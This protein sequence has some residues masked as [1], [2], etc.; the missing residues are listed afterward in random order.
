MTTTKELRVLVLAGEPGA[1]L[2]PVR[3]RFPD[4]ATFTCQSYDALPAALREHQPTIVLAAKIGREPFPRQTLVDSSSVQWIQASSAGVD[5]LQPLR[6]GI[7]LTSARGVHDDVLA[8]YV[9]CSVLMFNLHF[10]EFFRQQRDQVWSPQALEPTA[11]QCLVVVGL[12]SIGQLAAEKARKLGM[13]V[14]GVRA[15]PH[16]ALSRPELAPPDEIHAIDRLQEVAARADF[17][18]VTL[19]L[20]P[21]TRCLVGA[22]ILGSMKKG[23][24]LINISRGGIVDEKALVRFLRDG[25]LGGAV[26]DVFRE[27]PLPA[28]SELWNVDNLVITPHTGDIR[29]ARKKVVELFLEN[30]SRWKEGNPLLNIVDPERGY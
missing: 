18:A 8:D 28:E 1:Y 17:L 5:H 19:P 4:I 14:V 16:A 22:E 12:G 20:T 2:E 11:G 30:L 7:Q 21:R 27:E 3:T 9:L 25:P 23:S 26:V 15:R 13:R 6:S 24:V 29:G 10:H